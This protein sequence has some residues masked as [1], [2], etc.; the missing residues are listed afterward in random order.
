M[1]ISYE[2]R[3]HTRERK[4]WLGWW[5]RGAKC[6]KIAEII[7]CMSKKYTHMRE[8]RGHIKT[9]HFTWIYGYIHIISL[10]PP[11]SSLLCCLFFLCVREGEEIINF[12]FFNAFLLC[13]V[14]FPSHFSFSGFSFGCFFAGRPWMVKLEQLWPWLWFFHSYS[15]VFLSVNITLWCSG[16]VEQC[17]K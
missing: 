11:R 4:I 6:L 2:I 7:C 1:E 14:F 8:A 16:V 15:L 17:T 12:V 3:T 5:A 10:C 9:L 13:C